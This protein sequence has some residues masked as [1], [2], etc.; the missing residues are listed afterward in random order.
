VVV[1]AKGGSPDEPFMHLAAKMHIGV[2]SFVDERGVDLGLPLSA[3]PPHHGR[4][5]QA[6]YLRVSPNRLAGLPPG[7]AV[8]TVSLPGAGDARALVNLL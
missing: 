1:V 2:H 3:S 8:L 5:E 6:V 7:R 4:A